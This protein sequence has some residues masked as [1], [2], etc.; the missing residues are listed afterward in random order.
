MN[1]PYNWC[2]GINFCDTSNNLKIF[3]LIPYSR[4]TA[5]FH[6]EYCEKTAV[7]MR[8]FTILPTIYWKSSGVAK[9]NYLT[10]H[11]ICIYIHFSWW[12]KVLSQNKDRDN[13][14][15]HYLCYETEGGNSVSLLRYGHGCF[16]AGN[17]IPTPVTPNHL[18]P[19]EAKAYV[20]LHS[21][22]LQDHYSR[23][24]LDGQM[25]DSFLHKC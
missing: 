6:W 18:F 12:S 13:T 8:I 4:H 2:E 16:R 19:A 10:H 24:C 23:S 17:P 21:D 22:K 1:H 7:L 11:D 5:G 15:R 14:R 25:R 20:R 9:W 3:Y